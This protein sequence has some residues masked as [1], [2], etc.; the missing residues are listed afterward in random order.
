MG[1]RL[2][3]FYEMPFN[4]F[5][6]WLNGWENKRQREILDNQYLAYHAMIGPHLD[7]KKI[8][9]F[10]KFTNNEEPS[11][12]ISQEGKD[13]LL[14]EYQEYLRIKEEKENEFHSRNTG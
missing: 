6:I 13:A 9:S 5:L 4:E 11:V 7:P 10:Q 3:D 12:K 8:P 14:A 1:I 2:H